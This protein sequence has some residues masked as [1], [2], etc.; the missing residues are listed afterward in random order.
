MSGHS[1]WSSIKHQKALTDAKKGKVFSKLAREITIAARDGG[2]DPESNPRLRPIMEKARSVNM[3]KENVERAIKK[4]TG[5]IAGE[6]LEEI[7]LEAFGPA[8]ATLIIE[9]ITDNKNR[10]LGEIK[11][12]LSENKGKMAS[13]GSVKWL[14]EKKG[15]IAVNNEQKTGKE[16]LELVAIEAGADDFSWEENFFS[17]YTKPEN[18]ETARKILEKKG[19]KIDSVSLGWVA[20]ETKTLSEEEKKS[21][22]NLFEELDEN[23]S[24]QNIYSNLK[25]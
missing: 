8:G 11:K 14:F 23:D 21:C 19:L 5:E 13:E 24:V 16:E 1:H 4:G 20:K 12:I 10:T 3:P 22:E 6:K 25:I 2:G 7:T 15:V 17:V 18:L 9:A